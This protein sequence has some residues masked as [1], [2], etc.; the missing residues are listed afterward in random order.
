MIKIDSQYVVAAQNAD[1]PGE[2]AYLLQLAMKLE[3]ATI[4]PYLAAA[5]SLKSGHNGDIFNTLKSISEEEMLHM[6][7]IGN[8]LNAI[9]QT[10]I[11]ADKS[12]IPSYPGPLPL[13]IG[14][15]LQVGIEKFSMNLIQNVFMEIEKPETPLHFEVLAQAGDIE[16]S[17]IGEFY[18]ASVSYTH[19]TL[20]TICSV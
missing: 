1:D 3:H 16:F 19:L 13:S 14:S 17:T 6:A 9:G 11:I 2:L 10:P 12:F 18:I 20:P 7:L 5:Y 8:I 15:G 4:P